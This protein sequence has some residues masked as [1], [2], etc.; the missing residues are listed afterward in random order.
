MY[1]YD[2]PYFYNCFYLIIGVGYIDA[3]IHKIG[4][5]LYFIFINYKKKRLER[6]KEWRLGL[7]KILKS[8]AFANGIVSKTYLLSF[9]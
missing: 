1:F 8:I 6:R 7:N 2:F 5:V 3:V 4:M 9:L